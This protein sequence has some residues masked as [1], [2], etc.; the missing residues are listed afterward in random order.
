MKQNQTLM[1]KY[2]SS[3]GNYVNLYFCWHA[4]SSRVKQLACARLHILQANLVN[5]YLLTHAIIRYLLTLFPQELVVHYQLICVCPLP[6]PKKIFCQYR[7]ACQLVKLLFNISDSVNNEGGGLQG[8]RRQSW[9][10]VWNKKIV[11]TAMV[12]GAQG[13]LSRRGAMMKPCSVPNLEFFLAK[14]F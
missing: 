8:V 5:K 7:P 13:G 11:H 12:R 3:N 14:K 6:P 10:S 4:S 1:I 2:T 9:S